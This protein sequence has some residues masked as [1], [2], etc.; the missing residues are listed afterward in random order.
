MTDIVKYLRE[1]GY[2]PELDS[3]LIRPTIEARPAA[4]QYPKPLMPELKNF[5]IT[6]EV[7]DANGNVT[8]PAQ[9]DQAGF[10]TAESK[11]K[12]D[13]RLWLDDSR[14][15]DRDMKAHHDSIDRHSKYQVKHDKAVGE[16]KQFFEHHKFVQVY[17]HPS[18]VNDKTVFNAMSAIED[19]YRSTQSS[20]STT[21]QWLIHSSGIDIPKDQRHHLQVWIATLEKFNHV[22]KHAAHMGTCFE[23]VEALIVNKVDRTLIDAGVTAIINMDVKQHLKGIAKASVEVLIRE[24]FLSFLLKTLPDPSTPLGS[25]LSVIKNTIETS[26]SRHYTSFDLIMTAMQQALNIAELNAE[27]VHPGKA[28]GKEV[29]KGLMVTIFD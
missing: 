3:T 10:D 4:I 20:G 7:L 27:G 6:P 17:D 19:I 8:T 9:Y 15:Y 11:W 5:V 14:Q 26:G 1:L 28:K 25:R 22:Y 24:M 13:L 23:E 18:F 29:E 12:S 2:G 16:L 21:I